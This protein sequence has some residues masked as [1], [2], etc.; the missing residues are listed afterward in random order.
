[1][2]LLV[3]FFFLLHMQVGFEPCRVPGDHRLH[4]PH[5]LADADPTL[6][7][8]HGPSLCQKTA[9]YDLPGPFHESCAWRHGRTVNQ[10]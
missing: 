6:L 2:E 5:D 1:M 4:L 7:C 8:V 3:S 9:G 10:R